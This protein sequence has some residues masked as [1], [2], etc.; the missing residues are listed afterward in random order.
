M[1]FKPQI[2]TCAA[3]A[4]LKVSACRPTIVDGNFNGGIVKSQSR[5]GIRFVGVEFERF[6]KRSQE[7]SLEKRT[8]IAPNSTSARRSSSKATM[9]FSSKASAARGEGPSPWAM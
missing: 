9:H 5:L 2:A 6:A 3:M 4:L 8:V 1:N 7:I